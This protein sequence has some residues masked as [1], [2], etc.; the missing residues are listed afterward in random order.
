M[1]VYRLKVTTKTSEKTVVLSQNQ[2]V[3]IPA[4]DN[5]KYQ[6]FNEQGELVNELKAIE[7]N[8][9]DI[10]IY[11]EGAKEPSLILENYYSHY[12]IDNPQ[13]LS[14]ISASLATGSKDSPFIL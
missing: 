6:I 4:E 2:T 7:L 8:Q 9:E 13:Y 12:P 1:S 10:G 14:D 5:T 3:K 11:L